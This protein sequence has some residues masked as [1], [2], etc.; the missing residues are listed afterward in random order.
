MSLNRREH[1]LHRERKADNIRDL[2]NN[3]QIDYSVIKPIKAGFHGTSQLQAV[4]PRE[5]IPKV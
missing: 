2:T 5:K 3:I 1:Y 4:S